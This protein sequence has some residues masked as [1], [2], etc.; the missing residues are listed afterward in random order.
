M[1]VFGLVLCRHD[2]ITC[3]N[4]RRPLGLGLG[5]VVM[6]MGGVTVGVTVTCVDRRCP[7]GLV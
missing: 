7:V 5:L 1:L 2:R 3:V 4:R 6:V